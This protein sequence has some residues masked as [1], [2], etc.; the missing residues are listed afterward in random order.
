MMLTPYS[1]YRTDGSI[2]IGEIDWPEEPSLAQ[3]KA[4]VEPIVGGP[5][6]HVRVLDPAAD[7]YRDMFVDETGHVR[8]EGPK[9]RNEMATALYRNNWLVH[10]G[11][12][13]EDLPWIAG[14]AVLIDR[15][16]WR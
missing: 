5:L 10:E 11:G 3:I 8:A 15:I 1:I 14:D 4:L 2:W 6:E 16:V 12:E 13:P 7:D 9:P